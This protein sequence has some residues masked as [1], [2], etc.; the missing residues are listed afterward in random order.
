M[1]AMRLSLL[2]SFLAVLPAIASQPTTVLDLW[3]GQPPGEV[4]AN[5]PEQDTSKPGEGLVAGKPLI[6]LANVT[7]PELQVF[8][9][10]K[11]KSTGTAVVVCPGGAF[12]ILA[13]DLEGTEV[14]E[15]LNSIGVAAI[16]LK[17][18]V[19]TVSLEPRWLTPLIDGQR[20]ISVVRTRAAEWDINPN[21][22]GILGFSAGGHLATRC[23]LG[24]AER[25]YTSVDDADKA[26]CRPDFAALIYAAYAYDDKTKQ[27]AADVVVPKDTPPLFFIHAY[28]DNISPLNSLLLAAE[29]KKAGVSAEVHIYDAGGHGYGLRPQ[30]NLPVTTWPKRCEEWMQRKGWLTRANQD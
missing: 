24:F 16:V 15:W 10:P 7:K 11:H 1:P 2:L 8:L 14:A 29:A 26:S 25:K 6:R 4:K 18:R 21:R 20:A 19:P 5:G 9:P 30:A 28:D 13:M 27:L 3:P 22:I 12:R 23:A 17:Y